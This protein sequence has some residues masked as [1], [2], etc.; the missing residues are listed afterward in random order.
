MSQVQVI[1]DPSRHGFGISGVAALLGNL[2]QD[3]NAKAE[4]E[5]AKQEAVKAQAAKNY[6]ALAAGSNMSPY[7]AGQ[8]LPPD[9]ASDPTLSGLSQVKQSGPE[10][11]AAQL[12]SVKNAEQ[13]RLIGVNPSDPSTSID[14]YVGHQETVTG[15]SVSKDALTAHLMSQYSTMS[16]VMP[17]GSPNTTKQAIGVKLKLLT[18][19][20]TTTRTNSAEAMAAD[21]LA[22]QKEL[23]DQKAQ[24]QREL[25]DLRA[26]RRTDSQTRSIEA[27]L[28]R[29]LLMVGA[30]QQAAGIVPAGQGPIA[31][32]AAGNPAV[33]GPNTDLRGK[34]SPDTI[35]VLKNPGTKI[36]AKYYQEL[37]GREIHSLSAMAG[38]PL[39]PPQSPSGDD[40]KRIVASGLATRNIESISELAHFFVAAGA[41]ITGPALGRYIRLQ[42]KTGSSLDMLGDILGGASD[43]PLTPQEQATLKQLPSVV[44]LDERGNVVSGGAL[45]ATTLRQAWNQGAQQVLMFENYLNAAETSATLPRNSAQSILDKFEAVGPN[46]VQEYQQLLGN[47]AGLKEHA[48]NVKFE[49]LSRLYGGSVPYV[50][51]KGMLWVYTGPKTKKA[52]GRVE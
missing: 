26:Q 13:Q 11:A 21:R 47:L 36:P 46:N 1:N 34:L 37:A 35:N 7:Q 23:A 33:A 5:K 4:A 28:E 40:N 52:I 27:A 14:D 44:S 30:K 15:K 22:Q 45:N 10:A 8:G 17:D 31:S 50:D 2:L 51:G 6:M 38:V 42:K 16:D 12:A 41:P 19:A 48:A 3:Q 43:R 29:T 24:V 32:D 20:D 18:D 25:D 9:L 39:T 49:V